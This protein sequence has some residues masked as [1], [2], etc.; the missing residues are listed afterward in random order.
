MKDITDA[1]Y[2]RAQ[3]ICKAIEIKNLCENHDFYL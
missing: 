2:I 3:R 1:D